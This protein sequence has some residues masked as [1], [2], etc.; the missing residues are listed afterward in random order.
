LGP[1]KKS[2]FPT[3]MFVTF[4]L[5]IPSWILFRAPNVRGAGELLAVL[6]TPWL[7]HQR[8]LSG[9]LYLQVAVLTLAVWSAKPVTTA[10]KRWIASAPALVEDCVTGLLLGGAAVFSVL[11]L[12]SQT[13]FIYFQF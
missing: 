3:G 8:S 2:A 10:A 9:T 5:L 13:T 7:H 4:V 1:A 12:K 6:F 11:Y